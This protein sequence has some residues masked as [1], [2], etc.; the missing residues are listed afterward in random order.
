MKKVLFIDRDG[1]ILVEPE[2]E[3]VD[4]FEKMEFLPGV[5]SNLHKIA[6]ELDFELVMVTNQDGLG[7]ESFPEDTFWPVQIK[8]LSILKGEG[9]EFAYVLIDRTFPHENASTRKPG[10]ALLK[11]YTNGKYDLSNSFVIGDRL[12]DVQLAK[13]LRAKSILIGADEDENADFSAKDWT[14]IYNYLKYPPR[15]AAE[16]RITKETAVKIEI[17]LDGTGQAGI[18]S[19][20]GFFDHMLE[21]F[22]KH[23][24]CDL[25]AEIKGDLH[26]DE[27]HM[28]EDTA[29]VLGKAFS[30]ALGD[31][32]GIERY[33]F[34][35][36]M[37]ESLAQVAI[38]L[39]GR[40]ELQWKVKFKREEIGDMP[41]EL[42]YHFFKS[43]ADSA[44]CTLHIRAKG[45]NEHHKIEAVF[46]AFARA[47]K[48]AVRRDPG[49][50][51]IPSTKGVI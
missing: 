48:M 23:S 36:P 17:N 20:V 12:S 14:E 40:S 9:I 44:R 46:K 33:G 7:T 2:D 26:V 49:N 31:K 3:Q 8:M 25:K 24:G 51:F 34:V 4:S 19:G 29:I 18:N 30:G 21:L 27:H 45:K 1:T 41:T 13:N 43:F 37:D 39:S 15:I 32:R 35:L 47:I 16:E 42:F 10:T 38:D 5:I 6:R 50:E 22:A 11:K 28:V